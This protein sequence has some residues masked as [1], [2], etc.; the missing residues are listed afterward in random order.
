MSDWTLNNDGLNLSGSITTSGSI[1]INP[2]YQPT[3]KQYVDEQIHYVGEG[4]DI[5]VDGDENLS[6][7]L[8]VCYKEIVDN[9]IVFNVFMDHVKKEPNPIED[10]MRMI[11]KKQKFDFTLSRNG[12]NL[13]ITGAQF[14]KIRNLIQTS[15][16]QYIEVEFISDNVEYNN[17]MKSELDKRF[18]KLDLLKDKINDK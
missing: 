7:V 14:I 2:N 6:S 1:W 3:T 4:I 10:V 18:E 5:E 11:R 15:A 12:Y 8:S 13:I 17:T 16:N 9:C